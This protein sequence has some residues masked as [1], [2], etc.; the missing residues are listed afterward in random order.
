MCACVAML[1]VEGWGS[2]FRERRR[3]GREKLQ[4]RLAARGVDFAGCIYSIYNDLY[5]S[6]TR[7]GK[8]LKIYYI[9]ASLASRDEIKLY[10][11]C[12]RSVLFSSNVIE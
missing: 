3:V 11:L 2:L 12:Y 8:L 4:D 7:E 5:N 6:F 10:S 1:F 9:F